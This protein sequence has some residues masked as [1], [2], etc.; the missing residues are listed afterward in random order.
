MVAVPWQGNAEGEW[1]LTVVAAVNW[2]TEIVVFADTRISCSTAADGPDSS[3]HTRAPQRTC[4]CLQKLYAIQ[5]E[6]GTGRGVVL[7][8]SG[9]VSAA[10]EVMVFLGKHKLRHLNPRVA[11]ANLGDRMR[12][13]IQEAVGE[14]DPEARRTLTFMLWD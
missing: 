11:M 12:G 1:P 14:L 5:G 3:G 2:L 9:G 8:F 6:R 4:D 7:G 10:G 13:W